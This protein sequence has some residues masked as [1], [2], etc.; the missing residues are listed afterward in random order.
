[1][2][3]TTKTTAK[4]K[5]AQSTKKTVAIKQLPTRKPTESLKIDKVVNQKIL[6]EE[7]TDQ[8]KGKLSL[9]DV[10]RVLTME[11]AVTIEYLKKG[12]RVCKRDFLTLEPRY[13]EGQK[14]WTSPLDQ[15]TY[16]IPAKLK[17]CARVGRGLKGLLVDAAAGQ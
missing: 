12:Y 3:K 2:K 13:Q 1:M 17:V 8:L 7:I 4:S 6:A 9:A 5:K 16:T 14:E 11:Q 10:V 15:K